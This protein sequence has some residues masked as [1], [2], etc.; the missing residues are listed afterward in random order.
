ME[1]GLKQ[2]ALLFLTA[3]AARVISTQRVVYL[4][5]KEAKTRVEVE[6]GSSVIFNCSLN[7]TN[8]KECNIEWHFC[9]S[10]NKKGACKNKSL[11]CNKTNHLSS[12]N[13]THSGRYSCK[14]VGKIPIPCIILS[15]ER[16]LYVSKSSMENTTVVASI[17]A[18]STNSGLVIQW[19]MWIIL[20]V[21]LFLLIILTVVCWLKIK[22]FHRS[23]AEP[24]YINTKKRHHLPQP[25]K[26]ADNLHPVGSC[27][28]HHSISSSARR[29]HKDKQACKP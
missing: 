6:V 26:S 20:G 11:N 17:Q 1:T 29:N 12:V 10:D 8:I 16:E 21:S 28:S 22:R 18:N 14:V 19:W 27:Q 3:L 25:V 7:T 23:K 24:V 2:F 9:P 15:T 5:E 13:E 4:T